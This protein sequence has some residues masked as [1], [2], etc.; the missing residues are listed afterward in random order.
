M[1]RKILRS[2]YKYKRADGT[3]VSVP[4][5][6]II[7][8]GAPGKGAKVIPKLEPGKLTSIGYNVNKSLL[9]RH[10][11]VN[12]GVRKY[13]YSPMIKRLNAVSV[14]LKRTSPKKSEKFRNDMEYLQKHH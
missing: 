12:K 11:A 7:D 6:Y 5:K 10:R 9:S 14:L 1:V 13:G 8:R 4:D 3:N 2:G